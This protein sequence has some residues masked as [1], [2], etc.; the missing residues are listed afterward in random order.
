MNLIERGLIIFVSLDYVGGQNVV[1][2]FHCPCGSVDFYRTIPS[3]MIGAM[4]VIEFVAYCDYFF[5]WC[6]RLFARAESVGAR[7]E[8]CAERGWRFAVGCLFFH[9]DGLSDADVE[10]LAGLAHDL[11]RQEQ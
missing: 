11:A 10:F 9:R 6:Y 4:F 7:T 1:R 5:V 3:G 2:V 8:E